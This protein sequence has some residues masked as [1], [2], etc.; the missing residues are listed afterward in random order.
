M[1]DNERIIQELEKLKKEI[2][3]N[4][5]WSDKMR[6]LYEGQIDAYNSAI[7]KINLQIKSLK[8]QQAIS[9]L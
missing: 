1:E 6:K 5:I 7:Q 4:L 9:Q 8:D 2:E 3:G